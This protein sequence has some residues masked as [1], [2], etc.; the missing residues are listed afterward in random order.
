MSGRIDFKPFGCDL[1]AAFSAPAIFIVVDALESSR[2]LGAFQ[3]A[4]PV[5]FGRHLLSLQGVHS[6]EPTNALLVEHDRIAFVFPRVFKRF[7]LFQPV[8]K[9]FLDCLHHKALPIRVLNLPS[10]GTI[11]F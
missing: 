3:L 9:R 10:L 4:P 2:N 1:A 6:A 5:C 8:E 7:Q 11:T